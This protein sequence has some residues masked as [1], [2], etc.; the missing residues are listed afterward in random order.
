MRDFVIY[1]DDDGTWRAECRELP[2]Y[3]AKGRTKDE[4]LEKIKSALLRFYPCRC[5]D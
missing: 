2:G 5:E 4:A 1:Q 3:T